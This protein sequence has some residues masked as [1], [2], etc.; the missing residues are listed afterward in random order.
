VRTLWTEAYRDPALLEA[1][2]GPASAR[3]LELQAHCPEGENFNHCLIQQEGSWPTR[4]IL[5]SACSRNSPIF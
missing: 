5:A 4:S 2:D 1:D 3:I